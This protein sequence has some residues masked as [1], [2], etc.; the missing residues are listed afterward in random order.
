MGKQCP[1]APHK[2]RLLVA[3]AKPSKPNGGGSLDPSAKK[4]TKPKGK[5]AAKGKAK[6]KASGA[7]KKTS[8]SQKGSPANGGKKDKKG[9]TPASSSQKPE[10]TPYA[11]EKDAFMETS[12]GRISKVSKST[13]QILP[14]LELVFKN[15]WFNCHLLKNRCIYIYIY[16]ILLT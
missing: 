7:P 15:A 12:L 16:L 6:A 11:T 3:A 4:K 1:V 8:G 2:Q 14:C 10:K 9:G 13:V 5:A